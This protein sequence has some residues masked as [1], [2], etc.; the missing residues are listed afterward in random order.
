MSR[1]QG[2]SRNASQAGSKHG[3][4]VGSQL[5]FSVLHDWGLVPSH[6]LPMTLF[7]HRLADGK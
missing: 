7:P 3:A 1:K 5:A 2:A 6:D 4:M